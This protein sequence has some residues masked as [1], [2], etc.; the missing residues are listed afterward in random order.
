MWGSILAASGSPP[1]AVRAAAS[2]A[3]QLG[4]FLHCNKPPRR[5]FRRPTAGRPCTQGTILANTKALHEDLDRDK[6]DFSTAVREQRAVAAPAAALK[7]SSWLTAG[8]AHKNP[9][10]ATQGP[11]LTSQRPCAAQEVF[12]AVYGEPLQAPLR[13]ACM[14][15]LPPAGLHLQERGLHWQHACSAA[16]FVESTRLARCRPAPEAAK[17][18]QW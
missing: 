13:F 8:L 14:L 17:P 9:G 3:W 18:P 16:A 5:N 11:A 4:P 1:H 6:Q 10:L 12:V 2:R 7:R 15:A